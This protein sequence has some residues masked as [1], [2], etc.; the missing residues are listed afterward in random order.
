MDGYTT[1]AHK[2]LKKLLERP[3]PGQNA[4]LRMAPLERPEKA[5]DPETQQAGVLVLLFSSYNELHTVLIQRAVYQG[6]HSGQIS[7]PGGKMETG[8]QDIVHTALRETHEEVGISSQQIRVLGKLTPLYI[9]VSNHMVQPVIGILNQSPRFIPD[10]KEVARI[11]EV[12]VN[13]LM[14]PG[15]LIENEG[16]LENNR[17]IKAPFYKYNGLRIWGATAMIMSEFL[18]IYREGFL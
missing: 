13:D 11:Y 1:E 17:H 15:C 5:S 9:P 8:D 7:F 18:E 14:K 2:R 12:R 6:V 4:Q 16:I 10:S 3:L